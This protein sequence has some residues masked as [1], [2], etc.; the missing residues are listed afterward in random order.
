MTAEQV[1]RDFYAAYARRDVDAMMAYVSDDIVEDLSGIGLVTG[2][3]QEREFLTDL[4][5]SFPD[6]VTEVTRVLPGGDVV[7]VEWRRHGTFSGAPWR[8]LLASGKP[9]ALRGGAFLEVHEDKIT[10]INGYYDTAEFARDIGALPPEGSRGERL[11]VA[12][13]RTRV[14]MRRIARTLNPRPRLRKP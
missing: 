7:A 10:R 5:A 4:L 2:A 11:G 8:G 12:I 9:F 1:V 14:R 3:R 13:F 6:L